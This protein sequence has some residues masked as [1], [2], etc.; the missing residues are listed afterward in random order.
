MK[1]AVIY[2]RESQKVINLFGQPNREKYGL[3]AIKRIVNSLRKGGHQ[4]QAFEGDKDLIDNL[5]EFMPRTLVGER[6]GMAFNLSYGIQGQARYTHVPGILEMVGVPYVGS[7][8]LAHSLALDKVVAKMLFVQNSLPTPAFAVLDNSGFDMPELDFPLIVKPKNESVSF[9]IRIVNNQLELRE[10]ADVIFNEYQQPVLVEQFIEGREINIGLL[11]NG[12]TLEAFKPA[13]LIFGEG[14]PQIYTEEDKRRT[15]GREI[16]VVCP[17]KLDAET[18]E[19]AQVIARKAFNVLGC[20][21]CARVDMRMDKDGNLYVLEVNSLPSLGEHGSYVAAAEVMD[22]DFARLVNRLVE[23]ASARYFGTPNPPE[24]V[25]ARKSPEEK[26]FGYLT[27]RRDQLEKR[28]ELWVGISS[29]SNDVVGIRQA[30]KQVSS[31]MRDMGM[32]LNDAFSDAP[33]VWTWE[34]DKGFKNGTLVICHIDVPYNSAMGGEHFHRDPEWLYGEG[35]GASRSPLV[36]LEFALRALQHARKLKSIPIGVVIYADE[37]RDTDESA[38]FIAKAAAEAKEVLVLRPGN[39]NDTIVV[40]RR[41]QRRYKA[42]FHG[43]PRK[44][45]Q[46][47]KNPEVMLQAVSALEDIAQ[48][49]NRKERLAVSTVD[50]RT[51]AYP[52]LLPHRVTAIIQA[53]FPNG[54]AADLL[55][56]RV[57]ERL[58]QSRA[59]LAMLSDRPSMPSRKI[60]NS[61]LKRIKDQANRWEI[62]VKTDT[63]LWPSVAGLVPPQVPVICGL[64]PI[65][66]ELYTGQEAVSRI[67][68]VQR[69][70]LLAEYLLSQST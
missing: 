25:K 66:K 38:D 3:A 4:V 56:E 17:A 47:D 32:Q 62:P 39:L 14:G 52:R 16:G 31:F 1:V 21:D 23:V 28:V 44:L 18:T 19:R 57:K 26:V 41:G 35:I 7:G 29:H 30:A 54:R 15:S 24:L 55:E 51:E 60:N 34:T 27:E 65:A 63:S 13:E 49:S 53:S 48:L 12:S 69:T 10:A 40:G 6:P 33:H 42:Y 64:G 46:S 43:K 37:G 70:L 5:E 61:L 9:G 68:L 2:N 20:Y 36:Q 8:P 50:I 67:S 59:E 22:L 58:Q 45:G 11:G